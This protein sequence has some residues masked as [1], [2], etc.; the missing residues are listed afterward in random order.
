MHFPW[1]P[2]LVARGV[3]GTWDPEAEAAET[4]TSRLQRRDLP[5]NKAGKSRC[6]TTGPTASHPS[7]PLLS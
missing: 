3:E 7:T 1:P 6:Q 2:E 5:A 4:V